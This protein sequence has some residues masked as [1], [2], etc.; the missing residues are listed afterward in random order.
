[1]EVASREEGPSQE[2]DGL[3]RAYHLTNPDFWLPSVSATFHGRDIFAPVAAHLASGAHPERMG[4]R[5][6]V[7]SLVTLP[8]IA[9]RVM[10]SGRATTV[11]GQVI[12]VDHFGNIITNLPNQL[13]G[14]LLED[15]TA[16][17]VVEIG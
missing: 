6:G 8:V 14:P 12:H 2:G 7:A 4:K 3:P 15:A 13:L 17:P 10:G 1:E 16:A 9:P 11:T 5:I